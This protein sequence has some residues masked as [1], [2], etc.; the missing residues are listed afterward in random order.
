MPRPGTLEQRLFREMCKPVFKP[1]VLDKAEML[2][3]KDLAKRAREEHNPRR[4]FL[5][6]KAKEDFFGQMDGRLVLV[7]QPLFFEYHQFVPKLNALFDL[8]YQFKGFPA[9]ILRLAASGTEWTTFSDSFCFTSS[10][11]K[12]IFGDPSPEK[13]TKVLKLLSKTPFLVLLGGFL[14]YRVMNVQE[15]TSYSQLP[16]TIAENQQ[17]TL[18]LLTAPGN[19]LATNISYHSQTLV[20]LMDSLES[21]QR[22]K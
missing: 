2:A 12:Y 17:Q 14:Q 4:D 8:D 22:K 19:S 16:T 15:L 6:S 10:P 3:Q 1:I 18:A 21:Q 13:L 9:E 20:N 7:L 11:N 5:V